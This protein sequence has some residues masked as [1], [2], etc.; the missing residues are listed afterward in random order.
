MNQCADSGQMLVIELPDH[1]L[2][3]VQPLDPA[4][5][6]DDLVNE[7]LETN[8]AFQALVAKSKASK[9][10]PFLAGAES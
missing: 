8:P 7:L 4:D 10:K 2:I 6:N 9:R 5:E 1:R 3:A